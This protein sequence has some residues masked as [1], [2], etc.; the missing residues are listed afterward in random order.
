[1]RM[2]KPCPDDDEDVEPSGGLPP[3]KTSSYYPTT[4]WDL[5]RSAKGSGPEAEAAST[6]IYERYKAPVLGQFKRYGFT[7]PED[8]CD[9]FFAKVFFPKLI[10]KAVEPKGHFRGLLGLVLHSYIVD[11]LR[12]RKRHPLDGASS[13]DP[14]REIP[15]EHDLEAELARHDAKLVVGRSYAQLKDQYASE[16]K[17][18]EFEFCLGSRA[19]ASG[20]EAAVELGTTEG[21]IRQLRLRA[22]RRLRNL[23]LKEVEVIARPGERDLEASRLIRLYRA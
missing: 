14:E 8:F 12:K 20:K 9:E 6:T 10:Q 4:I 21:N 2:N 7:D 15:S 11:Q 22:R 18:K 16:G 17:I 1:M 19:G 23:I 3:K 13:L 5:F